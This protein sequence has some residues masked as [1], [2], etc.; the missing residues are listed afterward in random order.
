VV[1]SNISELMENIVSLVEKKKFV[2]WLQANILK[3]PI[4][5]P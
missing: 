3:D 2:F 4:Q 1:E 5:V